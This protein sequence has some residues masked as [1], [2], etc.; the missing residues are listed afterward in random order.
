MKKVF[1]ILSSI[2]L[3]ACGHQK[4]WA[5]RTSYAKK[6]ALASSRDSI[7]AISQLSFHRRHRYQQ[8]IRRSDFGVRRAKM[9]LHY[10][11]VFGMVEADKSITTRQPAVL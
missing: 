2:A 10:F 6:E 8:S 5:P 3:V 9:F 1:F 7:S 11:D 4:K